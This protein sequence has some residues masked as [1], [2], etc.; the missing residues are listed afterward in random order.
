M[1]AFRRLAAR[2]GM[3]YEGSSYGN[4]EILPFA[5]FRRSTDPG[6]RNVIV[7]EFAGH[8]VAGFDVSI[9]IDGSNLGDFLRFRYSAALVHLD[10]TYP[11][12]LIE[13]RGLR[14]VERKLQGQLTVDDLGPSFELEEFDRRFRV[15][16]GDARWAHA[17]VD[18]RVMALA[19]SSP[20]GTCFELA[21]G[22][23]LCYRRIMPPGA[24]LALMPLAAAF[25]DRIPHVA[26]NW[27]LIEGSE[28]TG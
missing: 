15:V 11:R 27:D 17:L 24:A 13:S 4:L 28:T 9:R 21:L 7:G 14:W 6:I 3:H 26:S 2:S 8:Q 16:S 10:G 20:K 25:A 22:G 23:V 5:L 18:Q 12:V 1:S 19:L